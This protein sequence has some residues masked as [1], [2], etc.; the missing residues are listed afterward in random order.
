[1]K[2]DII[3]QMMNDPA[4]VDKYKAIDKV[5]P[6]PFSHGMKHIYDVLDLTDKISAVFHLSQREIL[7]LK[8]CEVLHDL[9]QV[10]GRE[11]QRLF[12]QAKSF[13]KSRN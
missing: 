11:N 2:N 12:E 8:A 7:I 1:M 13:H 4:I 6:Y 3:K 10:D 5:N 9:G